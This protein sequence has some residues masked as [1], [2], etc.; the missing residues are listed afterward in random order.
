MKFCSCKV[1]SPQQ[2]RH[3]WVLHRRNKDKNDIIVG[4]VLLPTWPM[5]EYKANQELLQNRLNEGG[6]FD[7]PIAFKA[8][9][10]LE[11]VFHNHDDLK[12][13]TYGFQFSK[14]QWKK[15]EID[16]FDL[17]GRFDEVGFGKL[18]GR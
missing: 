11:V 15:S 14:K 7:V 10:I 4:Q 2:L 17:M 8:A 18:S 16:C 9:D 6:A 1:S 13:T 12:R 3:Y 5:H